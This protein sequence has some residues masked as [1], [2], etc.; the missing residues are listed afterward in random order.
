LD[1][2]GVE[3]AWKLSYGIRQ[4][5]TGTKISKRMRHGEQNVQKILIFIEMNILA[6][7]K[8]KSPDEECH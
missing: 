4:V 1:A 3:A 6:K 7:M 8:Y 5:L 2:F